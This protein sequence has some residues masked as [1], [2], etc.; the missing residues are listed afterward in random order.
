[1]KTIL[2]ST[3]LVL[4]LAVAGLGQYIAGPDVYANFKSDGCSLFPDGNYRECCVVHDKAYFVGGSLKERREADK[5]LYKCVRG[6]G[7]GK[8]LASV[9]YLGVRFGGVSFLR[10]PFRWGFGHKYP[11]KEP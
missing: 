5:D 1:M 8:M 2:T 9:I 6:K 3:A 7:G 10:T 11:R 4:T